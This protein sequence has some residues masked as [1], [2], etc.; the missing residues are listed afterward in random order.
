MYLLFSSMRFVRSIVRSSV[1]SLVSLFVCLFVCLSFV[2]VLR[3]FFVGSAMARVT[4][5]RIYEKA[6]GKGKEVGRQI[7]HHRI[8][9]HKEPQEATGVQI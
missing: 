8:T 1:R 4:R 7:G 9:K 6:G 5:N 2:V 3:D